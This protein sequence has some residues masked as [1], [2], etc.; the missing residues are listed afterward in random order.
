MRRCCQSAVRSTGT[1]W[2]ATAGPGRSSPPVP[3]GTSTWA[4][5]TARSPPRCIGTPSWAWWRDAHP[6]YLRALRAAEADLALARVGTALPF[7]T[8]RFD[9]VSALDVLEHVADEAG[10][11]AELHRVLRPGGLLV[12]TVPGPARVLGARP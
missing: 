11:L 3:A 7:A 10:T 2:P 6:D 9:S 4:S 1:R 12:L 8:G 5:V